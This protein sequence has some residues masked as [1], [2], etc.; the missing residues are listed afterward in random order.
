MTDNLT[1]GKFEEN[2]TDIK[3]GFADENGWL[4]AGISKTTGTKLWVAESD[5]ICMEWNEAVKLTQ[6]LKNF[7]GYDGSKQFTE[8]HLKDRLMD[9]G[10]VRLPTEE[11]LN[12]LY[13]NKAAIGD[14]FFSLYPW[15]WSSSE[16]K[17]NIAY[18][19]NF[20]DGRQLPHLKNTNFS[21]RCVRTEPRPKL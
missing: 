9:D 20:R 17:N 1:T 4:Y 13:E 14:L 19:Q 6:E 3:V 18:I 11:E 21:V 15:Y 16:Y 2:A 7:K 12:Q 10:G 8:K 5:S